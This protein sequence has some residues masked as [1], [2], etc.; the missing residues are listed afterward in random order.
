MVSFHTVGHGWAGHGWVIPR[1]GET[2]AGK[3]KVEGECGRGGLAVVLS[4][5]Q[6][7]L[8]RRVAIKMLL[9]EWAGHREAVERFL[10]E[11][12]AP[13]RIRSEHVVQVFDID[14]LETGA[15]YLVFEYLEG[16]N[17]E[18]VVSTGGPVDVPTAIDWVL[19][20]CEA[21]AEAHKLGI[22]HG[23]L[24]A[25]NLVLAQGAGGQSCVKVI[26]F[27]LAGFEE[28]SSTRSRPTW[29]TQLMGSP[30]HMSPEQLRAGSV[31]DRRTDIWA[32]GAVLH[33]LLAG[34]PP[35]RAASVAELFGAILTQAPA[36]MAW[37]RKDVPLEVE[38]VIMRCLQKDPAARFQSVAELVDALAPCA[39]SGA[40]RVREYMPQVVHREA[41]SSRPILDLPLQPTE[42]MTDSSG[43]E[44]DTDPQAPPISTPASLNVVLPSLLILAAVGTLGLAGLY[45]AVH[46]HDAERIAAH[47]AIAQATLQSSAVSPEPSRALPDI[48]P[49]PPPSE[50]VEIRRVRP[51]SPHT[52]PA[53]RSARPAMAPSAE[54]AREQSPPAPGAGFAP[55]LATPPPTPADE[56]TSS[57]VAPDPY[58]P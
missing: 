30:H 9:P 37:F 46:R 31:T 5:L 1:P 25:S 24:E 20:V 35:F 22:V 34:Q 53:P 21:V 2:I 29:T 18:Q 50:K 45:Y 39:P 10:R 32:L 42:S 15:P 57:R 11:G 36:P 26:D 51:P 49:P 44:G 28:P 52:V 43:H 47:H 14:T 17:L 58:G 4:A 40:A 48:P 13:A 12:F 6:L 8:G 56:P 41:P 38:A 19:Q 33:E 7:G 55:W 3:Y 16:H 23:D 54:I 27:G